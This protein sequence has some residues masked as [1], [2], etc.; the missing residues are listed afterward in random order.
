MVLEHFGEEFDPET[1]CVKTWDNCN[2]AY[3]ITK[4]DVTDE[5]KTILSMVTYKDQYFLNTS[6]QLIN[7]CMGVKPYQK[8]DA[9]GKKHFGFMRNFLE[10]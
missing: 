10:A 7:Y 3:E 9:K 4:K 2:N 8:F 1:Q 5:A 6:T